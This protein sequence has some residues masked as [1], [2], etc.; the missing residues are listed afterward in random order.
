MDMRE[1]QDTAINTGIAISSYINQALKVLNELNPLTIIDNTES[2]GK[3]SP[4]SD[5][6]I[7]SLMNTWVGMYDKT[8]K[9]G[10]SLPCDLIQ[11][12]VEIARTL[13]DEKSKGT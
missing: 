8:L 13:K 3:G 5:E 10:E 6:K 7:Q 2:K 12:A 11:R 4:V 1:E 9:A